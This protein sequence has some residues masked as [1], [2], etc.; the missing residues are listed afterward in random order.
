[1][2]SLRPGSVSQAVFP[3]T[4]RRGV[5]GPRSLR[6][7]GLRGAGGRSPGPGRGRSGRTPPARARS[8]GRAPGGS[9]PRRPRP[10]HN[11]D[12]VTAGGSRRAGAGA[13]APGARGRGIPRAARAPPRLSGAAP[14]GSSRG[15]G[16]NG[17]R[18]PRPRGYRGAAGGAPGP[19]AGRPQSRGAPGRARAGSAETRSRLPGVAAQAATPL[20]AAQ[21]P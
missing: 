5:S 8:S 17:L 7:P 13:V 6:G 3:T 10:L 11:W 19:W 21:P 12:D 1:M 4:Y 9:K 2:P 16:N 18:L 14:R 15:C 20:P